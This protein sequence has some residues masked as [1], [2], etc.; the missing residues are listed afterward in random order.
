MFGHLG[1]QLTPVEVSQDIVTANQVVIA[2]PDAPTLLLRR[3]HGRSPTIVHIGHGARFPPEDR[4]AEIA[5]AL[6]DWL[7]RPR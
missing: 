5:A 2:D 7:P 6:T 1:R 3:E 4:P